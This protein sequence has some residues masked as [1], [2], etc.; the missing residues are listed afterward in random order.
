MSE[1]NF[2]EK[3]LIFFLIIGVTLFFVVYKYIGTQSVKRDGIFSKGVVVGSDSYKG[4][5]NVTVQYK[6]LNTIYES[7]IG[8]DLGKGAIGR[9]YF[10]QFK[11]EEPDEIV[12][13]REKP[14]PN[15]L[16]NEDAPK[17][18]WKEIPSCP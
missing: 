8:S 4:G 2:E 9:Q 13:H 11:P 15:C 16:T 10:I 12:F 6:Y 14:V 1:R 17:E 18:G 5:T 7:S 3:R